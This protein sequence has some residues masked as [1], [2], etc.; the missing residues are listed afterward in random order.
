MTVHDLAHEALHEFLHLDGKIFQTLKLLI[1]RPG[2]LTMEYFRGRRARYISPVRL[3]LTCSVLYFGISALAPGSTG[4]W[5]VTGTDVSTPEVAQALERVQ[6]AVNELREKLAHYAPR[7]MFVLMPVFALMTWALYRRAQPFYV[8]HLYYSIHFHAFVFFT[9]AAA[10]A[11]SFAG[12]AGE[13]AGTV[14]SL[15][16]FPYHFMALRRAFGRTRAETAWKGA[17]IAIAYCTLIGGIVASLF[18]LTMKKALG[19]A[20]LHAA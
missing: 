10:K 6:D 15:S 8:P 20:N 17:L 12:D 2:E 7:S 14:L 1:L 4:R 11:L 18:A 3:Y 13:V 5:Q 16:I 9:L 19:A